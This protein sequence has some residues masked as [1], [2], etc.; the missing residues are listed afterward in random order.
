MNAKRIIF[1]ENK[2]AHKGEDFRENKHIKYLMFCPLN[3]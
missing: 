1:H 3:S 2:F